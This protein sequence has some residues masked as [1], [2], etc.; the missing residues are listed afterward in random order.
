MSFSQEEFIILAK[1]EGRPASFIKAALEYANILIANNAPVIF[2]TTHLCEIIGVSYRKLRSIANDSS[3][4]YRFYQI[5]KKHS[6]GKRQIITPLTELRKI[7]DYI[8]KCVINKIQCHN[9][10]HAYEKNKSIKTNAIAHVNASAILNIDLF[11]FFDSITEYQVFNLFYGLGYTRELSWTFSQLT[12]VHLPNE[13]I[14][15]FNQHDYRSYRKFIPIGVRVLP[16]GAPTSPKLSNIILRD[17]DEALTNIAFANNLTY[18]RYS[19]D[20][21]FSGDVDSIDV[22][23][24]VKKEILKQELRINWNKVGIYKR[25]TKQM[26]TGLTVSN[27]LHI[28]RKFKKEVAKHI[29]CCIKFGV[30][31]HLQKINRT[32]QSLYRDWLLGK[33]LYINSIEPSVAEEMLVKFGK[34]DWSYL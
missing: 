34:I 5:S 17:F 32:P 26:V 18:T 29:Y 8:S 21:T 6:N 19:D 13:Y 7:Q 14:R 30:S 20:I 10:S 23:D 31:Q 27:G 28:P 9:S 25:G 22:L 2:S 4:H 16:Q 33:I 24:S 15:T 11:R 12:T 3:K 1:S